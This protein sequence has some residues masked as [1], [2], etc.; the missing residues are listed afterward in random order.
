[1]SAV[2]DYYIHCAENNVCPVEDL[3]HCPSE[4][5]RVWCDVPLRR[6]GT[7]TQY[8]I[9][10]ADARQ[11]ADAPQYVR[12][13]LECFGEIADEMLTCTGCGHK[14]PIV[15]VSPHGERWCAD[16]Q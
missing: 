2:C 16:C 12:E 5:A 13:F 6:G 1:M 15:S 4:F 7:I 11:W 8:G 10:V 14:G 3:E 9:S